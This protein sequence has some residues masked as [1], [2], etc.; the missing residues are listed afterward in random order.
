MNMRSVFLMMLFSFVFTSP[1]RADSDTSSPA[2]VTPACEVTARVLRSY[3][4]GKVDILVMSVL[5]QVREG[6]PVLYKDF[7]CNTEYD[8]STQANVE[9]L[10]SQ[11]P[12]LLAGQ[13]IRAYISGKI[14]QDQKETKVLENARVLDRPAPPALSHH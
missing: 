10:T 4:S 7:S 6:D 9:I 1:L 13:R 8:A 11:A 3:S 2:I 5:G 12:K 14:D